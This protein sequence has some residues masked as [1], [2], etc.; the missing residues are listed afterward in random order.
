MKKLFLSLIMLAGATIISISAWSQNKITGGDMQ[1]RISGHDTLWHIITT[2][3]GA[4]IAQTYNFGVT[5]SS[6]AYGA[7]GCL[8]VFGS[9]DGGSDMQTNYLYWA[10]VT[11]QGGKTYKLS[12]A[13][14]NNS[15]TWV[16]GSAGAWCQFEIGVTKPV[17]TGWD[18]YRE[19]LLGINT[20]NNCGADID[21]YIDVVALCAGSN[22]PYYK[23]P[24]SLSTGE[25]PAYV[26]MEIGA[27]TASDA[28]DFE[29]LIDELSLTDSAGGT[30][31]NL[32]GS[33]KQPVLTSYPN[34]A[35]DNITI[36]STLQEAGNV[37]IEL[38]NVLGEQVAM[39]ANKNLAAGR[40]DFPLDV[41]SLTDNVYF[42]SL[43]TN[44][45]TYTIK[46]LMER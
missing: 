45:Q 6:P 11:L 14:M 27:W 8:Q 16:S 32:L 40:Y 39:V 20:W 43:K 38:F 13:I 23:L 26:A 44:G 5:A 42:C 37:Q 46:L 25:H 34:P 2:Y 9:L 17:A 10:P 18:N 28:I 29:I 24:D 3:H 33:D 7:G 30:S 31:I 1:T 36:S 12:G 41:S 22:D 15:S 21:G 4:T 35:T 19:I